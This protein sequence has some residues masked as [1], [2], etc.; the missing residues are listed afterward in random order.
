[1]SKK[2]AELKTKWKQV[3]DKSEITDNAVASGIYEVV[4]TEKATIQFINKKPAF[5]PFLFVYNLALKFITKEKLRK[6]EKIADCILKTLCEAQIIKTPYN[7]LELKTF[8]TE[9]FTGCL[10]LL[11]STTRERNVFINSLKEF[12]TIPE[13]Q[14]YIIKKKNKYIIPPNLIASNKR[15]TETFAKYLEH[16]LGYLDIIM[17]RTPNGW[18]ELLKAKYN[19]YFDDK[20]TENRIWI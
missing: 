8:S 15:F 3:F 7:E 4:E 11:N 1:M 16:D 13:K 12:Y 10:T 5:T 9:D 19:L 14:K 17:T 2:R 20:I 18:M 6:K